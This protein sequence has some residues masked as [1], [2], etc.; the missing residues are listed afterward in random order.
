MTP[1]KSPFKAKKQLT[2]GNQTVSIRIFPN[3]YKLIS[4][5]AKSN[6]RTLSGQITYLLETH[7]EKLDDKSK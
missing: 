2:T 5:L 3:D 1:C 7:P 6:H 4:R